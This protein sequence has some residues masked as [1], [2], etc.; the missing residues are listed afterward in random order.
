VKAFLDIE[1]V[2]QVGS[3]VWSHLTNLAKTSSP[4]KLELQGL[5]ADNKL[6]DK[7]KLDFRK[8]SKNYEYSLFFDEY[9]FGLT[10]ES[11]VVFGIESYIPRSIFFNGTINLFGNSVNPFEFNIRMQ[12]LEKYVESIFGL[13]GPLNFDRMMDKF[14]FV[15]DKFK[16]IFN[17]DYGENNYDD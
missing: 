13:D 5:L 8:F 17:F 16:S 4:Q 2:N 7:F 14:G 11:N 6:E 12:G 15:Y 9:N 3:F 1:H 10:G